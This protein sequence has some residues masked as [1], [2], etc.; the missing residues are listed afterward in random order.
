M[1]T[2]PCVLLVVFDPA[3]SPDERVALTGFL[4]GYRGA[5]RDAYSLDLRQFVTWCDQHQLRLFRP[6][7]LTSRATPPVWHNAVWP[8]RPCRGDCA[9]GPGS[10]ATPK[11]KASSLSPPRFTSVEPA[12]TTSPTRWAWTEP[13]SGPCWWPLGWAQPSIT[14]CLPAGPQRPEG[15]RSHRG[16]H[17]SARSRAGPSN[18]EGA[19]QREQS[20]PH[21][22]GAAYR[23]G[24]RPGHRGAN[25][26]TNP[27]Q[28]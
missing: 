26:R 2:T 4:A 22:T 23:P 11:K 13:R 15:L 7:G 3:L 16:Q 18:P 1:Q 28:R 12:W 10:T 6:A 20:S 24:R 9:L 8:G 19:A 17:R 25:R 14:P 5:T 21:P 27:H